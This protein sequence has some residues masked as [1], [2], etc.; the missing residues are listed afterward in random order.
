[1]SHQLDEQKDF[2]ENIKDTMDKGHAEEIKNMYD[3]RIYE[4]DL[5]KSVLMK[6]Q[7]FDYRFPH[8]YSKVDTEL[9]EGRLPTEDPDA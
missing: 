8:K 4:L 5:S 6:I 3:K 9:T 1:M 2:E 7:G